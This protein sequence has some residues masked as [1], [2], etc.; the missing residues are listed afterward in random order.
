VKNYIFPTP[1]VDQKET[2][3]I[4]LLNARFKKLCEPKALAKLGKNIGKVIPSQVKDYFS[5]LG[6]S[7]TEKEVYKKVLEYLGTG[8]KDIQEIASKY[9]LPR[10]SII[11]R[12]NKV[13]PNNEITEPAEFCLARSYDIARLV[14]RFRDGGMLAGFVEGAATGALGF[15]GLIPNIALCTFI[16]FRAVQTVATFYGYDVKNDPAE[17][18]I[19]TEVFTNALSPSTANS[20]EVGDT[21]AKIM[22]FAEIATVKELLA[23]PYAEMAAHGGI[24][25]LIVQ[26]RA[27][28]NASAKKGLEQAGK[29]GL[30]ESLFKGVFRQ[31]GKGLGKKSVGRMIPGISAAI[32]AAFD[33][34][35]IKTVITYADVFYQKRFLL[36]KEQNISKLIPPPQ[37]IIYI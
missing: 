1:V 33:I 4:E 27:L 23:K 29:K 2:D 9:T 28:A 26:L 32:G 10:T 7:I 22:A 14:S 31:I 13:I 5:D 19:A 6:L 8:F 21:I 34:N 35:Q 25:L 3:S 17:M 11:K 37:D 16:S 15:A 12:V 36:E 30:E 24:A 20:D 18:V